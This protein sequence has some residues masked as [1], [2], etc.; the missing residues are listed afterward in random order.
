MTKEEVNESISQD[1]LDEQI[2]HELYS[3]DWRW[4]RFKNNPETLSGRIEEIIKF[5][6]DEL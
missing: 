4:N 5:A 2:H 6:E 3:R 1:N